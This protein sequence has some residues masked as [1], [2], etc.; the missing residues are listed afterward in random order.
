M[1]GRLTPR[2]SEVL[3]LVAA[4][5]TTG[6]IARRLDL[7]PRSV[8]SHRQAAMRR[9]GLRSLAEV[10][11]W[12]LHNGQVLGDADP[13]NAER[14]LATVREAPLMVLV[15]DREMRIRDASQAAVHAL[16]YSYEEL[17][18]LSASDLVADREDLEQRFA[19]LISSGADRGTIALR[20][21]DGSELRASYST[22]VR[23]VGDEVHYASV[24]ISE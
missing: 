3:A 11:D 16:G 5:H 18:Q 17:L 4:G 8:E 23:Y 22:T 7:S 9:L 13:W 12:A 21:K 2:Q 15:A 20:R 24:L 6:A 10:V 14:F 1:R 19:G